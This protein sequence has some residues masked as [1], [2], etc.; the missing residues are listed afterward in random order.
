[1][2]Q[3]VQ[4]NDNYYTIFDYEPEILDYIFP[5]ARLEIRRDRLLFGKDDDSGSEKS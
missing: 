5:P 2:I 1:M 4:P 3:M